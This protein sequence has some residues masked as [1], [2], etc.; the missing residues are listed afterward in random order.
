MVICSSRTACGRSLSAAEEDGAELLADVEVLNWNATNTSVRVG[1]SV[2]EFTAGY[3]VVTAGAWSGTLLKELDVDLTVRRKS[4]FWFEA[5]SSHYDLA[6]GFPV[7]LYE[8][9]AGTYY[10]FPK[11]DPRGIKV[12]EHSGG[13]T[14]DDPANVDRAINPRDERKLREFLS[15]C[16]PQVSDRVTDHAVCLYTM[17]PDENFIVDRHPVR[18]NVA[19]AAGLSG[20]GYKFAPVLGVALAD[21]TMKGSTSLPIDF[22]SLQRFR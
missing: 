19:F 21:L 10:G 20:H 15:E 12:A 9:P 5:D 3:L 14:I 4:L 11:L 13:Q 6:S 16:L 2:G 17:S 18:A 22:L 7:Y 1:T 8:M